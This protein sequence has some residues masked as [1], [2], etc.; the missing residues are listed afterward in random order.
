VWVIVNA[1]TESD[2]RL[3]ELGIR[4]RAARERLGQTQ[5]AA[6][7]SVGVHRTHLSAIEA[8]REN[9]TVGTLYRIA[10]HFG[11]SATSLLPD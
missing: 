11:V 4:V 8:G 10:D 9:I 6:A 1:V 5:A 3:L 2:A 7:E